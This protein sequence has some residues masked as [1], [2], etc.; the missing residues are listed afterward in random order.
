[1]NDEG[2]ARAACTKQAHL[3]VGSVIEGITNNDGILSE[4]KERK[5]NRL[6]HLWTENLKLVTDVNSSGVESHEHSD[7]CLPVAKHR[8]LTQ[9]IPRLVSVCGV[10]GP[11]APKMQRPSYAASTKAPVASRSSKQVRVHTPLPAPGCPTPANVD[12]TTDLLIGMKVHVNLSELLRCTGVMFPGVGSTTAHAKH[13]VPARVIALTAKG[14]VTSTARQLT[15]RLRFHNG[16]EL[17]THWPQN[18]HLRRTTRESEDALAVSGAHPEIR[19]Q[20]SSSN[21]NAGRA[22]PSGA[23]GPET[24]EATRERAAQDALRILLGDSTDLEEGLEQEEGRTLWDA[25]LTGL[26][27]LSGAGHETSDSEHEAEAEAEAG[28][29]S[30]HWLPPLDRRNPASALPAS[31]RRTGRDTAQTETALLA[32]GER[33][34]ASQLR[35]IEEA[36]GPAY[37]PRWLLSPPQRAVEAGV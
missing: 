10:T 24:E 20:L 23:R 36:F 14:G 1:M 12:D 33:V 22:A 37:S 35:E 16:A 8:R 3:I 19:R 2:L 25:G 21:S 15:V 9:P 18:A 26:D 32:T 34:L 17:E 5:L 13:W 27:G 4:G 11:P 29:G 30:G 7:A 31:R 28:E 6:R